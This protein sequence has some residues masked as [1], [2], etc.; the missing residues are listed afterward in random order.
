MPVGLV[1]VSHSAQLAAGVAE[2][3]GQMTQGKTPI[4]AAGGAGEGILGTS[5]EIITTAIQSVYGPEGVLVLLDLGSAILSTEMALEMLE[6]GQRERIA[7][8]YAPLVEGALAAALEASLGRN[9][10]EVRRAAEQTA[11]TEHLRQLKPLSQAEESASSGPIIQ[12]SEQLLPSSTTDTAEK[13]ETLEAQLTLA[14]PAGLHARPAGLLV[15]TAA[16]FNAKIQLSAHGKQADATSI[17]GVLS[18]GARQGDTVMMRAAGIDAQDALTALTELAQ[19]NFYESAETPVPTK[20]SSPG[21][22]AT[23]PQV[24]EAAPTTIP[25]MWRGVPTSPGTALGPAFLYVSRRPALIGVERRAIAPEQVQAEQDAL[26]SALETTARE[27]AALV[28]GGKSSLGKAEGAIFEAQA[29]MLRDP[30]LVDPSLRLIDEQRIDAASALAL[31]GEQ[32]AVLL[33]GL[34]DELLAARAA[35]VRDAVS[36]A[37]QHLRPYNEG[38]DAQPAASATNTINAMSQPSILVARELLP[39]D[40]ALLR[41]EAVLGICTVQGGPTAHAAILARALDIPALAGLDESALAAIQSGD[42]LGLDADNGLLYYEPTPQVRADLEQRAREHQ[43]QRA[44]LKRA[45]QQAQGPLTV[46]GHTVHLLA[47][48]ASEAEAEAARQW[49]AGGV[50]LLRTE[51]LFATARTLPD[52]QEQRARYVKVFNAFRGDTTRP[53]EPIVARTLDAGADKPM[54]ALNAVIGETGEANPALGLRGVRIH[55]KHP[56]LLEQQLRALL[57]AAGDTGIELHIMFP[58]ITTV[59]E[60]AEA[61]S[62]F[63][64]V[65]DELRAQQGNLPQRVPLGIMV[66]VPS[67]A[68]M[69]PELAAIADFFSIGANDLLQYTLATDRTNTSVSY[70][71]HPMQPAVLR[72]IHSVAEAGHRAGKPVAVCGEIAGDARLAPILVALGVD[73]LSMTPTL[74][75]TVRAALANWTEQDLAALAEKVLHA[76]TVAEVMSVSDQGD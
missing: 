44:E 74:L 39:S 11:R 48:I 37:V 32:Q 28:S 10:A 50:G 75:P 54:P 66:E 25:T 27:L 33:E 56:A 41:P 47:N 1:I 71:Y 61:R 6:P 65:Y 35:D 38:A 21:A 23:T 36:R 15:Q 34:D 4:V 64:R 69:A 70:L 14:N 24:V 29:L 73:E 16:R 76:K 20:T 52:E 19:A 40:T 13:S 45:A 57:L 5:V 9:L 7:L 46:G 17:F 3:A 55:L 63:E 42:L 22:P 31:V 62:I 8:T 58:M 2:L 12:Q 59:E 68:V 72:L 43:Q 67:A 26:R 51:F 30:E 49:G 60:L 18:L 53:A